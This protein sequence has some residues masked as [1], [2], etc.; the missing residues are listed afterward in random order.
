M[1]LQPGCLGLDAQR[2]KLLNILGILALVA[3]KV[4]ACSKNSVQIK[5]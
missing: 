1:V 5:Y 3:Y 2:Q 4:V